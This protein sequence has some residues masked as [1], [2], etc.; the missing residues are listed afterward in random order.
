VPVEDAAAK[1][2]ETGAQSVLIKGGHADG[3]E[4]RDYWTDGMQ[5]LWLSSPRIETRA[6]HG[7]GCILSAAITAAIALGRPVPEAIIAAKTFLNQ[8][9][10]SP[11]HAGAGCGP[12][13]IQP[14]RND[15][16]DR[17]TIR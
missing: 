5:S 12:M 10:R 13:M 17:P 4:C 7:T 1:M 15:P 11:A 2:L 9:L 8:C 6:S 16:Q 14:F 3:D